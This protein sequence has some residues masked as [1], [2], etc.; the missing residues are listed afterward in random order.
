[1]KL[2][3]SQIQGICEQEIMAASG[4]SGG[5]LASDRADALD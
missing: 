3:D 2:T 1:M 4:V 5:E